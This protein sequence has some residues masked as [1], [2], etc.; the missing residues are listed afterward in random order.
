MLTLTQ[1]LFNDIS[2]N[3]TDIINMKNV[4]LHTLK[5]RHDFFAVINRCHRNSLKKIYVNGCDGGISHSFTN[6]NV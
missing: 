1:I 6:H 2:K 5:S 4:N 3:N